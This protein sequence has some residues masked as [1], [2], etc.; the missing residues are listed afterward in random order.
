MGEREVPIHICLPGITHGGLEKVGE[1][2]RGSGGY[3]LSAK[4]EVAQH[5]FLGI[6]GASEWP[7][8]CFR[9]C[10]HAKSATCRQTMWHSSLFPNF[11][12]SE[13]NCLALP[14]VSISEF[15]LIS[16]IQETNADCICFGWGLSEVKYQSNI[17]KRLQSIY[18]VVVF[19]QQTEVTLANL[20][21]SNSHTIVSISNCFSEA[22]TKESLYTQELLLWQLLPVDK[23]YFLL[24]LL[25]ICHNV[26]FLSQMKQPQ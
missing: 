4:Q 2:E 14:K 17:S 11:L 8:V 21:G 12:K 3:S 19:S 22:H 5:L 13:S 26:A 15:S 20:T 1:W 6:Q 24:F 10:L 25:N 16:S 23:K 7:A 9:M 18:Q